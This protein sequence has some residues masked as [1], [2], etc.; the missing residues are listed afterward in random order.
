MLYF[1]NP[2]ETLSL[3]MIALSFLEFA[4]PKLPNE[5][6]MYYS[7]TIFQISF[8]N[9]NAQKDSQINI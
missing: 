1:K 6:S 4:D 9:N 3:N 2:L 7:C 5:L 8:P